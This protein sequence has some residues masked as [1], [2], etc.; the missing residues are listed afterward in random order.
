M[1]HNDYIYTVYG[2]DSTS[3]SERAA[4]GF[5]GG[6]YSSDGN[7]VVGDKQD[8]NQPAITTT[9]TKPAYFIE[10]VANWPYLSH[11]EAELMLAYEVST[12]GASDGYV[13]KKTTPS[14]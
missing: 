3:L 13:E 1:S 12:R 4:S 11:E 5:I 6:K 7:L 14:V 2:T 8:Q 10:T 9:P